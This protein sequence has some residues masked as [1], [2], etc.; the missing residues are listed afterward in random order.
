VGAAAAPPPPDHTRVGHLGAHVPGGCPP[1]HAGAERA[2][3]SC[4][5]A[6]TE[7]RRAATPATSHT[8]CL[9]LHQAQALR[10]ARAMSTFPG[11]MSL[12]RYPQ[13][14]V[15][16][17]ARA[18]CTMMGCTSAAG[19]P[20]WPP[21]AP[22]GPGPA[23]APAPPGCPGR[24]PWSGTPRPA[25]WSAGTAAEGCGAGAGPGP[26]CCGTPTPRS[27]ISAESRGWRYLR[28]HSDAQLRVEHL[29]HLPE[30]P[31]PGRRRRDLADAAKGS[32]ERGAQ[33]G[34]GRRLEDDVRARAQSRRARGRRPG[35]PPPRG[36]WGKAMARGPGRSL[37]D[38]YRSPLR[39]R[40]SEGAGAVGWLANA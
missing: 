21:T 25:P 37:T 9:P 18:S 14:C 36:P 2:P 10:E 29:A 5:A 27:R 4:K 12:C 17:R 19:S 24:S 40:E 35:T 31:S 1:H 13:P 20:R 3:P 6:C 28:A 32:G 15:Q 34:V 16:A 38:R 26:P 30:P 22:S 33:G 11:F 8:V 7:A 23:A 39:A